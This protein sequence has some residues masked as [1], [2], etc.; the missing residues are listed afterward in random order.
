MKEKLKNKIYLLKPYLKKEYIDTIFLL[1]AITIGIYYQWSLLNLAFFVFVVWLLLNSLKVQSLAKIAL[2][3]LILVPISLFL[4]KDNYAE[5]FGLFA[6]YFLI[7][8]VIGA[9]IEIKA[10]QDV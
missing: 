3:F 8:T 2:F 9:I 1:I 4:S 7:L 5:Q 10:S 6:Y